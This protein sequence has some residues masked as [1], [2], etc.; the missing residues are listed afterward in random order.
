MGRDSI[1]DF[2]LAS[3]CFSVSKCI[4]PCHV[5]FCTLESHSIVD[6]HL[7]PATSCNRLLKRRK[8][9]ACCYSD[10]HCHNLY[11][12]L[13]GNF[14]CDREALKG[15][16]IGRFPQTF[17]DVFVDMRHFSFLRCSFFLKVRNIV[18][19]RLGLS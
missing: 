6:E 1:L 3:S 19:Q 5:Y 15:F 18:Q 9:M 11:V 4:K 2:P 14:T 16:W 7:L 17:A 13:W 8:S 12:C 10:V